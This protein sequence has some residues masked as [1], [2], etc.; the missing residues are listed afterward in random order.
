MTPENFIL[1]CGGA[2][3]AILGLV[4]ISP[5]KVNPWSAV[6]KAIGKAI[7]AD[8]LA[9][10]HTVQIEQKET[11]EALDKHIKDDKAQKA[12]DD[13]YKAETHR[14]AFLAFN[15]SLLR[16]SC[17]HRKT[18]LTPSDTSTGMRRSA[19]NTPVTK[20]TAPH[21]L[22]PISAAFMTIG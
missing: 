3:A 14:A 9:D 8:V 17:T 6:A 7:N 21:M 5:I 15:T 19:G 11:R 2:V 22:S 18:S 12:A 4:E 16:G 1:F 20:I 13:E 10:L